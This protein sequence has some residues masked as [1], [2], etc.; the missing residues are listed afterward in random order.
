MYDAVTMCF[1]F[2]TQS[3]ATVGWNATGNRLWD[4]QHTEVRATSRTPP[5]DHVGL[6]NEPFHRLGVGDVQ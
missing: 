6:R 2:F 5:D 1:R 3:S 4:R